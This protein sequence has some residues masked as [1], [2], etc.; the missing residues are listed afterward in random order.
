MSLKGFVAGKQKLFFALGFVRLSQQV[1]VVCLNLLKK[2]RFLYLSKHCVM[3]GLPII[4]LLH[5]ALWKPMKKARKAIEKTIVQHNMKYQEVITW[6]T[7][8]FFRE[9]KDKVEYCKK[10]GCAV[11]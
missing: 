3:K 7:D 2:V 4:M 6:S 9:K 8:G 11:V 10:E 1:V 5:H